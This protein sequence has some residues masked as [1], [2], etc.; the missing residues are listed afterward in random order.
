MNVA[1]NA[2]GLDASEQD[3]DLALD[4]DPRARVRA[5]RLL[6]PGWVERGAGYVVRTAS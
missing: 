6:V 3:W 5:A 4:V 2:L 1:G